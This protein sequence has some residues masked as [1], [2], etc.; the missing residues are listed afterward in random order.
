[1]LR[2]LA[3]RYGYEL[4]AVVA[5]LLV[6]LV[7]AAVAITPVVSWTLTVA[8]ALLALPWALLTLRLDPG[9]RRA[10]LLRRARILGVH[11]VTFA[12]VGLCL[13]EKGLVLDQAARYGERYYIASYRTYTGGAAAFMVLGLL[14]RGSRL[15]RF[16]VAAAEHPARLMTL[17]FGLAATLGGFALTLPQALRRIGDASFLDGLFTATSAVCVTGLAVND[18]AETYSPFGQAVIL[19]LIQVGGLGIMVLSTFFAVLTGARLRVRSSAVLAEMIDADSLAGLRRSV[20]AIV[21]YAL[22]IEAAG[23]VA[24]YGAFQAFPEVA[25]PHDHPHPLAGAGDRWWAA[26]FH[27]VSAFC[28]AGFSLFDQSL[29]PMATS[30]PVLGVVMAL[31]VTGGLGFP[32][33][34]E[35]RRH[36]ALRLRRRR[37]P[38]L[39][40]HARVVLATSAGLVLAFTAVFLV[41]EWNGAMR[42]LP[43]HARV[44]AALFQSVS[45]RTAGFNTVDFG[46][47]APATLL[48]TCVAM[49]IG[50]SPGSTAGGIKTTTFATLHAVFMAEI[51]GEQRPRLFDRRVPAPVARRAIGVSFLGVTLAALVIVALLLVERHEPLR[52][53]FEAVSAFGTVGLSTGLTS[54]LG[55]AGRVVLICAMFAGRIGPLTLALALAARQR[56]LSHELPEERLA[57]G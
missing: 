43:W 27:S 21:V 12:L 14:S 57:I 16:L 47:M 1:V 46:A 10:S 6:A 25:F 34:D 26:V 37:P 29:V 42:H 30:W 22:A 40:L 56:Q 38:R 8:T 51:R 24:L 50:G 52:L 33:L 54:D 49:F 45:T 20:V 39:S 35:L 36:L 48:L 17:S 53:I 4:L 9:E 55:P 5:V 41:L 7:D 2:R 32:V 3:E 18:I 28:N 15:S 11:V 13:F 44:L 19:L 31:V 23:A